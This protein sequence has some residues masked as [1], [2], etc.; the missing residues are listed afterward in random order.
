MAARPQEP[1]RHSVSF[2]KLWLYAGCNDAAKSDGRWKIKGKRQAVYGK[3]ELS[4]AERI[5]AAKA[6]TEGAGP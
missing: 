3:S 2:G 4:L 5:T 6:L 1:A